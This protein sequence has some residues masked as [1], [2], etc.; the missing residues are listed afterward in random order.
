MH[1]CVHMTHGAHCEIP[2]AGWIFSAPS[3][4]SAQPV[5]L[6]VLCPAAL[7]ATQNAACMQTP[8]LS[9]LARAPSRPSGLERRCGLT[10]N[11]DIPTIATPTNIYMYTYKHIYVCA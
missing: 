10:V 5:W 4:P 9:C 3:S 11:P 1:I 6:C 7:S 2:K 8:Q